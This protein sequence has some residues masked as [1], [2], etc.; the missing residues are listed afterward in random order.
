MN[1]GM[2][3]DI[4]GHDWMDAVAGVDH[5][6]ADRWTLATIPKLDSY[7][8]VIHGNFSVGFPGKNCDSS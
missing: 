1:P 5:G 7:P 3:R 8:L 4:P 2:V 6:V